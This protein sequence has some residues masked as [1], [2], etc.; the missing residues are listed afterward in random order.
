MKKLKLLAGMFACVVFASGAFGD[1]LSLDDYINMIEK[2]NS[3]LI[4]IQANID[5]VQGKILEADR[6]YAAYFTAGASYTKDDSG[7]P[8]NPLAQTNEI[9]NTSYDASLS[10]LFGTGTKITL[11]FNGSRT[12]YD[13]TGFP[14]F[15]VTDL[16]PYIGL[17]QSLL[18]GLGGGATKAG[19]LKAQADARSALYLLE[20]KK[21]SVLLN[22][23]MA[24]WQ[25]SYARTVVDFR[26]TSLDRTKKILDWNQRRFDMDLAEKADLLQAQAAYK[27]GDLNLRLAQQNEVQASRNFNGFLNS[28]D[29]KVMFDVQ[30]FS[31]VGDN[32]T[33]ADKELVKRGQRADVLSALEDVK[34]AEQAAIVSRKSI[35]QDLVLTGQ[36]GLNGVDL[37]Y[38]VARDYVLN[39]NKP[40]YTIGLRYTLPLDF[41]NRSAI[42][43]GYESAKISAE[44]AAKSAQIKE[45]NDW[46][47]L[48]SN[49]E[50]AKERLGLSKQILGVQQNLVDEN[51]RL[52]SKGRTTTYYVLQSEQSLDDSTLNVYQNILELVGI[53]EQ[54]NAF[55]NSS[56]IIK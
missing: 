20:Y 53:Y 3:D 37:D 9:Q 29:E 38:A 39:G 33:Q 30:P 44:Q 43:K 7:R 4:S 46:L 26:K 1:V 27:M 42:S 52:L 15:D 5:A 28:S 50:N 13:Y 51:Q 23:R 34:S 45:S 31:E 49:W 54:A 22:A 55:Y 21:Q 17:E 24:Y 41:S 11:G 14:N 48:V 36:Y 47:G 6:V 18:Q 2:N 10:K 19:V 8:F 25:L 32:F 56:D 16:G 40:S 35:G 12:F